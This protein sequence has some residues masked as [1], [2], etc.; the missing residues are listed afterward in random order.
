MSQANKTLIRTAG[1]RRQSRN[2]EARLVDVPRLPRGASRS[3]ARR[4]AARGSSRRRANVCRSRRSS[5]GESA[6]R[7]W[8]GNEAFPTTSRRCASSASCHRRPC[9]LSA[10]RSEQDVARARR[11]LSLRR[12]PLPCD[13]EARAGRLLPLQAVPTRLGVCVCGQRS[14]SNEVLRARLGERSRLGVRVLAGKVS[15]ILSSLWLPSLQPHRSGSRDSPAPSRHARLRSGETAARPRLGQRKS[16]MAL[17]RRL[18]TAVHPRPAST[19]EAVESSTPRESP[20][21]S[22]PLDRGCRP[23]ATARWRLDSV[24]ER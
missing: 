5:S 24:S 10:G 1:P 18:P 4:R 8:C 20:H 6:S 19:R 7:R 15:R 13:G 11:G 14:G 16:S 3:L 9:R 21:R 17:H 2:G 22:C 12:C 23:S